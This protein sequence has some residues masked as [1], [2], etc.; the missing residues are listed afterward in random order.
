M[1]QEVNADTWKHFPMSETKAPLGFSGRYSG[2]DFTKIRA[3]YFIKDMDEKWFIYY[4]EPWLYF[5]RSWTGICIYQIHFASDGEGWNAVES[6]AAHDPD[7]YTQE[8]NEHDKHLVGKLITS[9]LLNKEDFLL[10]FKR[11]S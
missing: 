9:R 8:Q 4:E 11:L 2:A 10:K 3:G 1:P 6:W 7:N 5:H